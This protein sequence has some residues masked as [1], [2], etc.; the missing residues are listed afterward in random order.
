MDFG[1]LYY[2]IPSLR[3]LCTSSDWAVLFLQASY[4]FLFSLVF[5]FLS[6]SCLFYL[7][8]PHFLNMFLCLLKSHL[9]DVLTLPSSSN[10]FHAAV[11]PGLS[12]ELV[13]SSSISNN[14]LYV[15]WGTCLFL[16]CFIVYLCTQVF[17][18]ISV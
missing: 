8:I 5:F 18:I 15:F 13:V 2:S 1:A 10:V 9:P 7:G 6:F 11:P 16:Y 4:S 12:E 14:L 17:Y 3:A